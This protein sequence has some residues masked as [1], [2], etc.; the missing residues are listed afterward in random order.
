MCGLRVG[1]VQSQGQSCGNCD[2]LNVGRR[3]LWPHFN[4]PTIWVDSRRFDRRGWC[5]LLSDSQRRLSAREIFY[6]SDCSLLLHLHLYRSIMGTLGSEI[7]P[8]LRWPNIGPVML[9]SIY[10]VFK[11][12]GVL[13]LAV[14]EGR[15]FGQVAIFL[16]FQEFSKQLNLHLSK[17]L[18]EWGL[19]SFQA[20]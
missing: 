18:L 9:C 16:L 6:R 11:A 12:L 1:A 4:P 15:P 3:N 8:S 10:F 17:S 7:V 14:G 13:F 20:P 19:F 2:W 5:W